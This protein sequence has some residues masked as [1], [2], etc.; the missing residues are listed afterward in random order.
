MYKIRYAISSELMRLAI[1]VLPDEFTKECVSAGLMAA[2]EM[3]L[4]GLDDD[5]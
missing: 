1:W 4:E 5:D 3:I 2:A